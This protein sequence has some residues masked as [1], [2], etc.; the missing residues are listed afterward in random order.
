MI[1][2]RHSETVQMYKCNAHCAW[3]N[4]NVQNYV[5]LEMKTYMRALLIMLIMNFSEMFVVVCA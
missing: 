1:I 3:N 4:A 2:V 5:F